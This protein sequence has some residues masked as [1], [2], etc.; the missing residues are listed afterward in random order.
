MVFGEGRADLLGNEA[1][2]YSVAF[3]PTGTTLASGSNDQTVRFWSLFSTR[4]LGPPIGRPEGPVNAVAV[5]PNGALLAAAY[6]DGWARLWS[7]RTRRSVQPL[8]PKV[9][10][11]DSLA[12]SPDSKTLALASAWGVLMLFNIPKRQLAGL[13]FDEYASAQN[14]SQVKLTFS[15][16]GTLIGIVDD[17]PGDNH[18]GDVT[19][20]NVKTHRTLERSYPGSGALAFSADGKVAVMG[21]PA[22]QSNMIQFLNLHTGKTIAPELTGSSET[23]DA[24]AYSPNGKILASGSA[25][26]TLRLWDPVA[27]KSISG[28]LTGHTG[29]VDALAFSP[30]GKLVAT[31]SL[32]DTI[33]L[34]DVA[35]RQALGA[36]L[37]GDTGPV[38]DV[39]FSPDGRT[40]ASS[41]QDG[42]VR[43]WSVDPIGTYIKQLCGY[44][45]PG[46]AKS[47]WQE[48][49]L[50]VAYQP[51]PCP[52]RS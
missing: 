20:I 29:G 38:T 36:P 26:T 37:A 19:I 6:E 39:A 23:V 33:R 24:L 8:N 49:E 40:L 32:D 25:D 7:M 31:G 3:S 42:T 41:S 15:R 48:A 1:D 50:S 52:G 2:V 43:L 35:S 13:S 14:P 46:H 22:A 12:F 30:S 45:L 16:D 18:Q 10:P 44:I 27:H 51:P 47:I 34:W 17:N 21:G 5:S 11:I 28:P 4:Q 9:G